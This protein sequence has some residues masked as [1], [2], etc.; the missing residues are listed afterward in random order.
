MTRM[1]K[2]ERMRLLRRED[3][4]V[5]DKML[6]EMTPRVGNIIGIMRVREEEIENTIGIT[7]LN[8]EIIEEKEKEMLIVRAMKGDRDKVDG[9]K[10]ILLTEAETDMRV[11]ETEVNKTSGIQITCWIT[12]GTPVHLRVFFTFYYTTYREFIVI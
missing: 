1:K 2:E 7:T 11:V 4:T 12:K 3:K 8:T 10:N 5:I 6:R 9:M